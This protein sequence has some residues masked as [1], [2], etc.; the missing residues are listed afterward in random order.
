MG[1]NKK[2]IPRGM[3]DTEGIKKRVV[4]IDLLK[5]YITEDFVSLVV[6]ALRQGEA[7]SPLLR[8]AIV[9]PSGVKVQFGGLAGVSNP[10]SAKHSCPQDDLETMDLSAHTGLATGIKHWD[11]LRP[12]AHQAKHSP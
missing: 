12:P 11:F 2:D 1:I 4:H 5:P 7:P 8:P 3:G 9:T 10:A 6:A